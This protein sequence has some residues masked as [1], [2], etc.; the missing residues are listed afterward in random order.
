LDE[1]LSVR[2]T[3]R[4]FKLV[5]LWRQNPLA[6]LSKLSNPTVQKIIKPKD[7]KAEDVEISNSKQINLYDCL[8]YF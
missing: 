8:N 3:D 7:E 1:L 6:E 2:R 5:V 4:D